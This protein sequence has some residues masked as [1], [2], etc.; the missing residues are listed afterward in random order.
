MTWNVCELNY[1][2][3]GSLIAQA[4]SVAGPLCNA[5]LSTYYNLIIKYGW[6]DHKLKRIEKWLHIVPTMLGSLIAIVPLVA[7]L[8]VPGTWGCWFGNTQYPMG[9]DSAETCERGWNSNYYFWPIFF[10]LWAA[11]CYVAGSMYLIYRH[12]RSL[13]QRLIRY[14][15]VASVQSNTER[16]EQERRQ[17]AKSRNVMIQSLLYSGAMFLVLFWAVIAMMLPQFNL[18]TPLW[19]LTLF[20]LC[21]PA[22]GIFN[23]MIHLKRTGQVPNINNSSTAS[24]FLSRVRTSRSSMRSSIGSAAKSFRK[25]S[26]SSDLNPRTKEDNNNN[27]SDEEDKNNKNLSNKMEEL[28]V[29]DGN[30]I[31]NEETLDLTD[32]FEEN[33]V[34]TKAPIHP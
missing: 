16:R 24:S 27:P 18:P 7:K 8:Y 34:S 12:V 4:L 19:V 31:S 23:M 29:C 15:S 28:N 32:K 30:I 20:A 3:A 25:K 22:Q 5:S 9:C 13:E 2:S 33:Y 10:L 11:P 21:N 26:T 1:H 17:Y 6:S 14:N